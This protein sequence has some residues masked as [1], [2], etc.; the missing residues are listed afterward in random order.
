[1]V[2]EECPE[3]H[4]GKTIN[5]ILIAGA[6]AT[7][8][9]PVLR[10]ILVPSYGWQSMTWF[11]ILAI[12]IAFLVIPMKETRA[13]QSLTVS[14]SSNGSD[15]KMWYNEITQPIKLHLKK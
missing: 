11:G 13:F 14:K 8:L 3:E 12:P 5:L 4:R 9:I 6:S 15:K 7:L 2:S 1:M 10:S